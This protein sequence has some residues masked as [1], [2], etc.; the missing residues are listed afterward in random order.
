MGL[1]EINHTSFT[2]ADVDAAAKW[3]CE[4]LGFEVMSDMHR[5]QGYCEAVTG[6]PGAALHII[7]VKGGGYAIELIEYTQSKGAKIDSATNNVGSAHV[8]YNVENLRETHA[9]LTARGVRLISEPIPIT[10]GANKGG[11]VIY[12]EDLDGNTL[13]FIE[14]PK[15]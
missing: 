9:D 1:I 7:Y 15:V 5:P 8:A 14:R 4:N 3:Y 12:L 11:L 13:E 10:E 6:I 2:V